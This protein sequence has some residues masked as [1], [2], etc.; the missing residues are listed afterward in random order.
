MDR[1][2][3]LKVTAATGASGALAGCGNPEHQIIRF[4]PEE[5]L[6]PGIAR[7]KPS[8]CPLC[9]AGCGILVRIM[10]G[11]AEVTRKGEAG[12]IERGLAK[13]W[14]AARRIPSARA[15]CVCGAR[16]Q[17]RSRIIRIALR[18]RSRDQVSAV[19]VHFG[20]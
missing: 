18:I 17:S 11:D 12:V 13:N 19:R 4:I 14:K 6:T 10:D 2:D 16:R 8:I 20:Q 7:W 15:D 5:T 3:F 9:P 1:R